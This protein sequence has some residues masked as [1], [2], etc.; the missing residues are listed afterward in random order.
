MIRYTILLLLF[1]KMVT[2]QTITP[3][4]F[5]SGGNTHTVSI[6]SQPVIYT[7]N[8]G[9]VFTETISNSGTIVTQG[10]IQP[11][12]TVINNT[13]VTVLYGHVTCLDKADGYI[14][15]EIQ[16][17]PPAA[18]V[19]YSWTPNA[20]CPSNDCDK[21]DSL[22]AGNYSVDVIINYTVNAN[23]KQMVFPNSITINDSQEPCKIKIYS[24]V[25]P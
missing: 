6:N 2:S 8:I 14:K 4:V 9:E 5:N 20:L 11:K 25:T 22:S 15:V 1:V 17:L 10:F 18:Q 19:I 24:G 21:I 12:P 23:P 13:S 7:D 16:N 3:S